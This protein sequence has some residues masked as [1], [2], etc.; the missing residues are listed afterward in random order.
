ML[1][2]R[3]AIDPVT[4]GWYRDHSGWHFVVKVPDWVAR[5]ERQELVPWLQNYAA[6]I[7][8]ERPLWAVG[9]RPVRDGFVLDAYPTRDEAELARHL[10]Q[11]VLEHTYV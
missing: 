9:I 6:T 10:L 4:Y 1:L 5:A 7:R 8:T 11:S 3:S 2:P